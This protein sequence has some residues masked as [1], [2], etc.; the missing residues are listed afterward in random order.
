MSEETVFHAILKREIPTRI[1][2]ED[3]DVLVIH[4]IRPKATTH[5]LFIPKRFVASIADIDSTTADIPG[6]LIAQAKQFAETHNIRGYRLQCNVG[7][8]GGQEVPYLHLHFLSDQAL[9]AQK[10]V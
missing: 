5:L 3:A 7:K 9:Q 4:D 10:A 6:M 1:A 8:E 2:Y